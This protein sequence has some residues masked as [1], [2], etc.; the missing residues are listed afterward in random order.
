MP[1]LPCYGDP[2]IKQVRL[3][4]E[5]APRWQQGLLV[6]LVL[7][8]VV[9]GVASVDGYWNWTLIVVLPLIYGAGWTANEYFRDRRRACD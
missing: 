9:V 7:A 8:L 4:I 5:A 3:R 1:T 2:V 6:T